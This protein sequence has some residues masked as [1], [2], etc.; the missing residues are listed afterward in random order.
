[1]KE[2]LYAEFKPAS[3]I[4]RDHLA[5]DRTLLA[6]ERTLLAY[7]RSGVAMIMA[8]FT[9]LHF[10]EHGWFWVVGLAC[11]PIGILTGS[12]GIWR[13]VRMHRAITLV[14]RQSAMNDP[15]AR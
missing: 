12:I 6:N 4:L 13:Y 11:P 15:E 2:N 10:L 14:R 3:L 9:I 1:M 5:I 8:G 7:L